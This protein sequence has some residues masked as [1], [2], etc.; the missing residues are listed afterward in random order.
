MIAQFALASG[1]DGGTY[2][3]VVVA[4]TVGPIGTTATCT[5]TGCARVRGCARGC[6]VGAVGACACGARTR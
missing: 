5:R 3:V 2:M 1:G 6:V 4:L